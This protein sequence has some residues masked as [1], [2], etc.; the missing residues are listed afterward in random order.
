[1][2]FKIFAELN[3]DFASR[4]L[5]TEKK[6]KQP[7]QPACRA[8]PQSKAN[9]STCSHHHCVLLCR[10]SHHLHRASGVLKVTD[11]GEHTNYSGIS[12]FLIVITLVV[13]N[14]SVFIFALYPP[15][16]PSHFASSSLSSVMS[17]SRP[18]P[19]QIAI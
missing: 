2:F 9:W 3:L 13:L 8:R 15:S 1:L 19:E 5:L 14:L 18:N 16:R 4:S 11:S 10:L 6:V 7:V 17:S 12:G